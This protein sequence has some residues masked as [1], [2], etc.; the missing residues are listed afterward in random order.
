[1]IQLLLAFSILSTNV[2]ADKTGNQ[3]DNLC[4][5]NFSNP[6]SAVQLAESAGSPLLKQ[7]A[8]SSCRNVTLL[9][10]ISSS[11]EGETKTKL[12]EAIEDHSSPTQAETLENCKPECNDNNTNRIYESLIAKEIFYDPHLRKEYAKI[13]S[14]AFLS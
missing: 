4:Y 14:F 5:G 2:F 13:L 3:P 1:M 10:L 6:D 8:T 12:F 9:K 11:P 7:I